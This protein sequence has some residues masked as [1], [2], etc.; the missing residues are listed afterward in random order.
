[1]GANFQKWLAFYIVSIIAGYAFCV[2]FLNVPQGNIQVANI[3]LGTLLGIL[4]T[5]ATFYW[6]SSDK[7]R[8]QSPT[9][10]DVTKVETPKTLPIDDT[11]H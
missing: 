3:A 9:D 11:P 2:T 1:M 8:P 6:G 7:S 4:G 10:T 5:I